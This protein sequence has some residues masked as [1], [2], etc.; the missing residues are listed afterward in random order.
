MAQSQDNPT[1][2]TAT[3]VNPNQ[4][5]GCAQLGE[6]APKF[7]ELNDD[8]L[9]CCR[10]RELVIL[11]QFLTFIFNDIAENILRKDTKTLLCEVLTTPQNKGKPQ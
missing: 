5:A 6:F 9:L 4:T 1:R 8:V 11:T 3:E 7:A 2:L 10:A